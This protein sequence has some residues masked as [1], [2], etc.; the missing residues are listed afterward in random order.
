MIDLKH[1]LPSGGTC[2]LVVG[3]LL[4]AACS[5]IEQPAGASLS[6]EAIYGENAY[7]SDSVAGMRWLDDGSG[8]TLVERVRSTDG[9]D[10]GFTGEEIVYYSAAGAD[11]RILVAADRLVPSGAEQPLEIDDYAWSDDRRRLLVYTNSQRV[12][13]S[14]S[15]GDY[16][17]LNLENN[18]LTKLGGP[19]ADEASLMFAKFAPDADRVAY[20]HDNNIYLENLTS[21]TIDQLTQ[22]PDEQ[23]INGLFDW[24]YEEEF[25]IRDGFR[26][27]PDGEHIAF[28]RLDTEGSQDFILINNTDEL[29]PTLTR[30]PYPKVGET[31]AAAFIGIVEVDSGATVFVN[32]PGEPREMYI[33][34]M[35]WAGNSRQVAI[36][37]VNRKQDTNTVYLADL[38]GELQAVLVEAEET[39]LDRFRD[40]VWLNEGKAFL[41]YSERSGWREIYRVSRNGSEMTDLIP[42]E[43]DVISTEAVDETNGWLYFTA[44]VENATQRYL[45]R[46]RLDGSGEMTRL[47]PDRFSGT[48]SYQISPD[49]AWAV[50]EHSRFGHPPQTRLVSLPDHDS[51]RVLVGNNA[52]REQIESLATGDAGF[53]EVTTRDCLTLD[54]YLMKPADFD[55]GQEYP[56][57]FYVYGEVAS[58]TVTDSW[59][60]STYL[61][62]LLLTQNG[63]LVASIDNRGT[64]AP[65]GRDW[66]KSVYGAVGVLA[67]RDQ[68]DALQQMAAR[69]NFIDTG[70]IGIWGHSGGG[71]MTLNML[72]RYPEHYHVGIALAPVTDQR[73]YDTIYQE[74]YSG[75]LP[76]YADAY[77]EASPIT[78][79]ENLQGD[80]LLIHGTADDNVHY[81]QSERLVNELIRYNRQFTFMSYPNRTHSLREGAGTSLHLRTLMTN[82]LIDHLNQQE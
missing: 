79:A 9:E 74:R 71:S 18:S 15:R 34:R 52:L 62:H 23:T 24:V 72:F 61:W 43:F 45:Y 69:W 6:L 70:R 35:D 68:Y 67:S 5:A 7:E 31:N 20:V 50:H 60:G 47:T 13:R 51:R 65:R 11:R 38:D 33:P 44:A 16:W 49:A 81:Q 14:N 77:V 19:D 28:W 42:G 30:F 58:T 56:L 17:V 27:S 41:W 78:H 55:P 63:F 64:A 4:V 12:W 3:G 32:L 59:G 76:E 10:N 2:A 75:L 80:L 25:G 73:L 46:V 48:N 66:R 40:I 39:F 36:Q 37:H 53:F 26:W 82:Y 8:Y 21:G 22:S 57:V 54:G 29:Y 1:Y